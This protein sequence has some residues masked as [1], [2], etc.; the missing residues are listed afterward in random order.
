MKIL[1][2]LWAKQTRSDH[3]LADDFNRSWA[4]GEAHDEGW[5]EA[6][7]MIPEIL[8]AVEFAAVKHRDQKRKDAAGT[9]YI[10]HPVAVAALLADVEGIRHKEGLIAA[11]LHDTIEDTGTTPQEIEDRFGGNIRQIVM[12]VSDDK[13]LEKDTR[14]MLQIINAPRLSRTARLISI[15]D[16][17]ANVSDMIHSPP[18][19]WSA[20][21]QLHYLDWSQKV[22][23]GCRGCD[24]RLGALFDQTV[25]AARRAV[26]VH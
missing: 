3:T 19:G 9:P 24:S 13:S 5:S 8:R 14:K 7:G 21:R 10:N 4:L 15:A 22:V 25:A 11:L 12:E 6:A 2:N 23:A 26:S 20:E 1:K 16:K 17:I 18:V